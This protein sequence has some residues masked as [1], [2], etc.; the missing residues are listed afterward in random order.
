MT[1]DD[2]RVI[3]LIQTINFLLSISPRQI[4]TAS[5]CV[6]DGKRFLRPSLF[7]VVMGG[8][9]L[10]V[11]TDDTVVRRVSKVIGHKGYNPDT[12]KNDVAVLKLD[13]PVPENHPT[14][15]PIPLS[16]ILTARRVGEKCQISGWG[17]L[18]YVEDRPTS[19][20]WLVAANISINSKAD[21]NRVQSHDGTVGNG[22]F[23]AGPFEGGIDSCQGRAFY[24]SKS[25]QFLMMILGDSGGPLA[26]NGALVG[27]TSHGFECGLPNYPGIYM[28]VAYYSKFITTGVSSSSSSIIMNFLLICSSVIAL[29]FIDL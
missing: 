14:V 11:R 20:P 10:F 23:C 15:R 4:L 1:A 13:A 26:C 3:F 27:I 7:V 19:S 24:E 28:D 5:H 12:F 18:E 8:L 25:S 21:C 22:M 17:T 2:V 6:H 9:G 16:G 29:L